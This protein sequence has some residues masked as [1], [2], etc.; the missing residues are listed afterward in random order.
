M[1]GE[2]TRL[3]QGPPSQSQVPTSS[4][5]TEGALRP[6]QASAPGPSTAEDPQIPGARRG[7]PGARPRPAGSRGAGLPRRSPAETLQ[8][9]ALT[10]APGRRRRA[11]RP[12]RGPDTVDP[13]ARRRPRPQ[14]AGEKAAE[15]L[16][17]SD[18]R[19]D[20]KGPGSD[21]LQA[22]PSWTRNLAFGT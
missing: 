18:G 17:S 6:S 14:L 12:P 7:A 1:G 9:R 22:L 20:L 19:P 10:A 5:G 11:D 16:T 8:L 3:L 21:S 13:P 4:P 15:M 2:D